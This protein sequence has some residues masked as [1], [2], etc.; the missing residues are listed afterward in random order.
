[1]R[2]NHP[3]KQAPVNHSIIYG[4]TLSW[5]LLILLDC[6]VFWQCGAKKKLLANTVSGSDSA[7][8]TPSFSHQ[9]VS[10]L[11]ISLHLRQQ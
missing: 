2:L 9:K 10:L 4:L 3:Q 7:I 11:V 1:M 5:V 6:A 8:A